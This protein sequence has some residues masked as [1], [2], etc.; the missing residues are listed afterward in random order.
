MTSTHAGSKFYSTLS[1]LAVA[2]LSAA[3]LLYAYLGFYTRYFGDDYCTAH[4]LRE[5]GFIESQ[6]HWYVGWT[7]RFSFT[8][9]VTA[10]ELLGPA[11]AQV[12]PALSLLLWLA[13][14]AWAV[15]QLA[16]GRRRHPF[17]DSLLLAE[18]GVFATLNHVP[19]LAQ[20]LYWQTGSLTYV[21]PLILLTVYAGLVVRALRRA[22]GGGA[23]WPL[24][25]AAFAL[26]F[27]AGGFSDSYAVLQVGALALVLAMCLWLLPAGQRRVALR[28]IAAGLAGALV[29]LVVVALSPGNGVRKESFSPPPTLFS[30]V[31]LSLLYSAQFA[32]VSVMRAPLTT[33]AMLAGG[34]LVGLQTQNG[35]GRPGGGRLW[36]LL[37]LLPFAAFAFVLMC[38]APAA[39]VMATPLP[40]RAFIIPR[41]MLVCTVV[42]WAY[43]AGTALRRFFPE[44]QSAPTILKAAV[45]AL[46][47]LL[48]LAPAAA[49]RRTLALIPRARANALDWDRAEREI[50]AARERGEAD[51]TVRA[52]EDL[53]MG[54]GA[55]GPDLNL[56]RD[57]ASWKN[58]CAA[59]YYGIR[60]LRAE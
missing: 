60:S 19:N 1:A 25:A 46:T 56:E 50:R 53:E 4:V 41:F 36:R 33:L 28:L 30:A 43:L 22:G 12:L 51:V 13:A 18:L 55:A 23:G 48:M 7:G 57:P 42:C 59:S 20:S 52:A 14:G 16:A 37:A 49:A 54:L 3:L 17:R 29:A 38:S 26:T 44:G 39:Y 31:R 45:G 9:A 11:V 5:V 10:A 35:A 8:F 24:A 21:A 6:R 34:A 32:Y 27:V 40:D 15:Y 2:A 47:L 58:K